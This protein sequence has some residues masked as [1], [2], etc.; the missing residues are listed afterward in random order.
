MNVKGWGKSSS[1]ESTMQTIKCTSCGK[2][3]LEA[4][5][6]EIKKICPKCGTVVYVVVTSKGIIDLSKHDKIKV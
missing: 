3:L 5:S 2:V 6:G 4:A 1:N